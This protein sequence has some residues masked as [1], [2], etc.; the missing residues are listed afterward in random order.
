M[1]ALLP[2]EQRVVDEKT[3]LDELRSKLAAFFDTETFKLVAPGEKNRLSRQFV[4]MQA[5][6]SILGERIAVFTCPEEFR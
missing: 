1:I 5:Y 3:A 4:A 6:S 2:H